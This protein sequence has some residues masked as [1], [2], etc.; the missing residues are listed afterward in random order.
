MFLKGFFEFFHIINEDTTKLCAPR[1]H[2][3][4]LVV[5]IYCD[6]I[7]LVLTMQLKGGYGNEI[8]AHDCWPSF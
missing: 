1:Q 6:N 7:L 2:I 4:Y 3:F 5:Y 8:C